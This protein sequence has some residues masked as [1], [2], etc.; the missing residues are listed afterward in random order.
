L[1][2]AIYDPG[3][4]TA[5]PN[6]V[7]EWGTGRAPKPGVQRF[8]RVE[9]DIKVVVY[10]DGMDPTDRMQ[11]VPKPTHMDVRLNDGLT[12]T[13]LDRVPWPS[14]LGIAEACARRRGVNPDDFLRE[15]GIASPKNQ[16]RRPL[17]KHH[18]GR[19]GH[20]PEFFEA[21]AA[22][23]HEVRENSPQLSPAAIVAKRYGKSVNTVNGWFRICR[24]K[25]LIP[26]VKQR[27]V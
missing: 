6:V 2:Y 20:P 25:N 27:G 1:S 15:L 10:F 23:W 3:S 19:P 7:V 13:A 21:I 22:Q 12:P 8:G 17:P 14:I 4:S 11:A 26:E 24:Q 16:R 18:P 5:P 9:P